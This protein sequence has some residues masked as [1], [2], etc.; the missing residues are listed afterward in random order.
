MLPVVCLALRLLLRTW[1]CSDPGSFLSNMLYPPDICRSFSL[2]LMSGI[3]SQR[4]LG[5]LSLTVHLSIWRLISFSSG[6]FFFNLL[7]ERGVSQPCSTAFSLLSLEFLLDKTSCSLFHDALSTS[8][9]DLSALTIAMLGTGQQR[10]PGTVPIS[11]GTFTSPL[12]S[13]HFS[14]PGSGVL[15]SGVLP[16][17]K[18]PASYGAGGRWGKAVG[19][20]LGCCQKQKDQVKG[21]W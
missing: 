17:N 14:S 3:S 5:C 9:S 2:S 13:S 21:F 12:L 18:A 11:I 15:T 20:L 19:G 4:I 8:S 16:E 1:C 6:L 7:P 10:G